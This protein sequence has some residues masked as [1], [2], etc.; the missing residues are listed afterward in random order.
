[1]ATIIF[2]TLAHSYYLYYDGRLFPYCFL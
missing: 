1:V 2:A